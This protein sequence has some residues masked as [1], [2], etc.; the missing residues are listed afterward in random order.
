MNESS[1]YKGNLLNVVGKIYTGTLV[2]R[3]SKV[4]ESLIDDEQGGFRAGKGYVD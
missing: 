2:E 3:V 1:N 4:T